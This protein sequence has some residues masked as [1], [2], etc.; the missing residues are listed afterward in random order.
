MPARSAIDEAR[1]S[2]GVERAE[3]AQKRMQERMEERMEKRVGEQGQAARNTGWSCATCT[4]A[5]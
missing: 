3:E 5:M 4:G 1:V 2:P